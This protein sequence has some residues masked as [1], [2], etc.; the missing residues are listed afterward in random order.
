[1]IRFVVQLY[2]QIIHIDD[3]VSTENDDTLNESYSFRNQASRLT[4]PERALYAG[5]NQYLAKAGG[6]KQAYRSRDTP[7]RARGRTV[8]AGA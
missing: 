7:A 5:C 8:F 2:L 3:E 4:Q 6:S 1:V